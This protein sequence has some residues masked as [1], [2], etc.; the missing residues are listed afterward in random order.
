MK[1]LMLVLL[2]LSGCSHKGFVGKDAD[3]SASVEFNCECDCDND[4]VGDIKL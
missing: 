4:I 2:F 1:T 3:C